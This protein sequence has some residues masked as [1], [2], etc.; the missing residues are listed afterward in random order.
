MNRL[1]KLSVK[2]EKMTKRLKYLEQENDEL[3]EEIEEIKSSSYSID[4]KSKLLLD[5]ISKTLKRD[6]DETYQNFDLETI[7]K[8]KNE[9]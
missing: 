5:N 6:D 7:I 1:S 9:K 4:Q 8:S 2:I 3:R